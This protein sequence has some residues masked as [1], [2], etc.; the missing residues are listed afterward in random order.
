MCF[1]F[2]G[3]WLE[4]AVDRAGAVLEPEILVVG[5]AEVWELTGAAAVA[6]P[7]PK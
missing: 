5:T 1:F 3:H 2:E 7:I 4:L 6:P